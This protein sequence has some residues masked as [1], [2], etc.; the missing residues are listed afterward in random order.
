MVPIH[1]SQNS[2]FCVQTINFN[3]GHKL[4]AILYILE[5]LATL[6]EKSLKF[7]FSLGTFLLGELLKVYR[8]CTKSV[9]CIIAQVLDNSL[10]ECTGIEATP[11]Q[12]I[13]H[14]PQYYYR[15]PTLS[16]KVHFIRTTGCRWSLSLV[17][18]GKHCTDLY[19]RH[20]LIVV[21]ML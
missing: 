12:M 2:C 9:V 15:Y 21:T 16:W 18:C 10:P 3:L 8:P 19:S 7:I 5:M 1:P 11:Y 4:P 20:L 6:A 17:P 14:H 13:I